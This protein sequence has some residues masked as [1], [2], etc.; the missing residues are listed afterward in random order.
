MHTDPRKEDFDDYSEDYDRAL[1]EGLSV[2]GEN[3]EYFATGRI[4]WLRGR[5]DELRERSDRV[6]DFG[7]GDG[8]ASELILKYLGAR[9]TIGVDTSS[10]MVALGRRKYGSDCSRF[11]HMN[12]YRPNADVDLVYSNGVFHHI[13]PSERPQALDYVY[14]CLRAGGLFALWENN[15]WNPG[16]R[17]VMSRIP[18]D[19]DAIPLTPRESRVS[20]QAAG[21]EIVY[22]DFLF[23]FPHAL[24]F[25][26]WL[27][28]FVS[29]YPFGAQYLI[30]CRRPS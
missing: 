23:L 7:C 21:F 25:L 16:T 12:E 28:P 14:R 18:F 1:A 9:E 20:V 10:R 8:S 17:Y 2:A 30:L 4:Q 15:P 19:R 3:K 5:L 22:S 13:A 11:F 24:R 27:E 26:R 29:R 6:L